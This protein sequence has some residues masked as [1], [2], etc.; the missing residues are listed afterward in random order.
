[1]A[2][3]LESDDDDEDSENQISDTKT[4][5]LIEYAREKD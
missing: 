5:F 4:N 3:M 1:M 2:N